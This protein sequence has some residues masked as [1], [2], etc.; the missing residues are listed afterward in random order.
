MSRYY[1]AFTAL[2]LILVAGLVHGFWTDRWVVSTAPAEAAARLE[3]L[4]LEAG[5]WK[6]EP[7]EVNSKSAEAITGRLCRRYTNRSTGSVVTIALVSGLP[8]PVSIH[9]P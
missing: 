2:T 8:G 3:Q 7:L 6:G 9:T 5:D 1:P 4:P